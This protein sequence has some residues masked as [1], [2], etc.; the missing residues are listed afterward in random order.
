MWKCSICGKQNSDELNICNCGLNRTRDFCGKRVLSPLSVNDRE[1]YVRYR[2]ELAADR[3]AQY[4]TQK[5]YWEGIRQEEEEKRL[6]A[7]REEREKEEALARAREEYRRKQE[8]EQRRQA[9]SR[10][11]AQTNRDSFNRQQVREQERIFE[12]RLAFWKRQLPRAFTV[13]AGIYYAPSIPTGVLNTAVAAIGHGKVRP[14]EV[15]AV[16]ALKPSGNA[17]YAEGS[18]GSE[19]L[20]VTKD[21]WIYLSGRNNVKGKVEYGEALSNIAGM[22]M[23]DAHTLDISAR[24]SVTTLTLPWYILSR[25]FINLFVAAQSDLLG[26]ATMTAV[27]MTEEEIKNIESH[28]AGAAKGLFILAIILLFAGFIFW[29]VFF[30]VGIALDVCFVIILIAAIKASQVKSA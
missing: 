10:T 12:K 29:G 4:E 11:G 20:L 1:E 8:E 3:K 6:A 25:E 22:R 5:A 26:K 28:R 13:Q 21:N 23:K 7:G 14:D 16:V 17:P 24:G 2:N 15:L 9:N 27:Y 19:G 30:P 18:G